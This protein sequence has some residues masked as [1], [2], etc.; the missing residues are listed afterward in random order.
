MDSKDNS[1][2][3]FEAHR[4][5]GQAKVEVEVGMMWLSQGSQGKPISLLH[6]EEAGKIFSPE[7]CVSA[8]SQTCGKI[9]FR[10]FEPLSLFV[11]ESTGN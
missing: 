7:S 1:R 9:N 6:L 5:E 3:G 4:G 2:R 11:M 10:G 8:K